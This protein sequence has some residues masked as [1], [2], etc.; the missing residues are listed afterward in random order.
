[1]KKQTIRWILILT[2]LVFVPAA[3]S[4]DRTQP[5]TIGAQASASPNADTQTTNIQEY[6]ELLHSDVRQ[7][8]AEMMGAVMQCTA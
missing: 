4:Q 5:T 7:Q 6:I 1:M 3:S 2:L 8:K